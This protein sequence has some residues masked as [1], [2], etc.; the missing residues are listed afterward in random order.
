MSSRPVVLCNKGLSSVNTDFTYMLPS[1]S[2]LHIGLQI[3]F[4]QKNAI[5]N[6]VRCEVLYKLCALWHM[7]SS[8]ISVILSTYS[9]IIDKDLHKQKKMRM[10]NVEAPILQTRIIL[11]V[12]TYYLR[13]YSLNYQVKVLF[14]CTLWR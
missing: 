14:L 7:K 4:V 1:N 9:K 6:A 11:E 13:S 10:I 2:P 3:K 5:R 12:T 8:K